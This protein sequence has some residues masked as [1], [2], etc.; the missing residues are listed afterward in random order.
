[1]SAA[2]D[3]ESGGGGSRKEER[4]TAREGLKAFG[5]TPVKLLSRPQIKKGLQSSNVS[6]LLF[7]LTK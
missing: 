5:V 6:N 1:M 7:P 4:D 3:E 2:V